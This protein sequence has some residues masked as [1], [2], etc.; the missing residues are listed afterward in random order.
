ME[1]GRVCVKTAGREAGKKCVVVDT[2]EKGMVVVSGPDV[3]RRRCN[4]LHLQPLPKVAEIKKG[5]SDKEVCKL[6]GVEYK[7]PVPSK[8]PAKKEVKK[9]AEKKVEKKEEKKKEKKK[10]G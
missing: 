1:I 10:K 8:K 9:P 2:A 6:F 5:A 7:E 4:P 3:K